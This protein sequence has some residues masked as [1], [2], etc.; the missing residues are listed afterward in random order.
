MRALPSSKMESLRARSRKV[1][2]ADASAEVQRWKAY[3]AEWVKRALR[4]E[5][6]LAAQCLNESEI[7][8]A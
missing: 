6:E 5:T 1:A 7:I 2:S 8:P 4:A 3:A